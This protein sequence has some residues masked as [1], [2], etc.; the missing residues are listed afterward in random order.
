MKNLKKIALV[1]LASGSF[2]F[3]SVLAGEL[4]VTGGVTATYGKGEASSGLGISNELDFNANGELDNGMT[5]KWQTQLDNAGMNNDDTRLEIGTSY[6][7]I[8]LYISEGG[9]ASKYGYGAGALAAGSDYAG[10]TSGDSAMQFGVNTD[11][12]N[13][14]QYHTP[15]DLLP[16]GITAKVAYV[17]NLSD[18]DGASA[19]STGTVETKKDGNNLTHVRLDASPIDGLTVGADYAKSSGQV[20]VTKYE[21]ESAGAYAK[22]VAGPITVGFSRTGYQPSKI[23]TDGATVTYETDSYGIKFAVNEN[24]SISY[25]EEKS[26]KRSSSTLNE[27]ATRAAATTTDYKVDHIQ[28]A[29]VIGGATLG[30]A[31]AD[32]SNVAY[33]AGRADKQTIFSL[34]MAF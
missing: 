10:L 29:Y 25:G 28:A 9:L 34:A 17:P 24:L 6:G 8:G 20:S 21:M 3:S 13:N 33:T 16:F 5:W 4:S 7:T 1:I 26:T 2:I 19:K 30:V 27:T 23:V 22:Y 32:G 12:Y 11:S 18:G 15:A 31:I 14:V